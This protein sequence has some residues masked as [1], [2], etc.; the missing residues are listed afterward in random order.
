MMP[1]NRKK[2]PPIRS[3]I[4]EGIV[5]R[6]NVDFTDGMRID[7]EV[8]GDLMAV[9]DAP[10]LLVVGAKARVVGKVNADHVI[11]VGEVVGP[12]MCS[13]LLE[14]QPTARIDG[15]ISYELLEMHPGAVVQGE[16]KPLRMADKP[17]LMLAASNDA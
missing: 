11:I 5:L 8:H 2:Q 9:R 7:G 13:G 10:S 17:P 3:L 4:G 15:D 1:W 6:G 16:L 12:V 14:L